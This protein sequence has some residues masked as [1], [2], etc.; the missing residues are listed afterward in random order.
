MILYFLLIFSLYFLF[1]AALLAGWNRVQKQNFQPDATNDLF[2]SVVIAVRNE[3]ENIN[4][5]LSSLQKQRFPRGQFEVLIIDDDSNDD[6]VEQIERFMKTSAHNLELLRKNNKHENVQSPKKAA[7][8]K[9]IE[10][11]K[12]DIILTTDGDTWFGPGWIENTIAPFR[13]ENVNFV[14]SPVALASGKQLFGRMQSLEFAS[15]IGTGAALIGLRYPLMCNGANL[16]FRKSAFQAVGGYE[17]NT[18][19]ASG[20]DVYLMQKIH[21]ASPDSVIFCNNSD[22]IVSTLPQKTWREFVHQRRRWASKWNR[23]L[24]RF[25]WILPVFLFVHY[26]SFLAAIVI[27]FIVPSAA[28]TLSVLLLTKI[29]LD[30]LFLKKVM[31]FS[32]LRF[33]LLTVLISELIYPFYALLIGSMVHVGGYEWKGRSFKQ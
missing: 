14:S 30:T 5:L 24:L 15:L 25:S 7:L 29:V 18:N 3:G 8:S 22:A 26:A 6:T 27:A 33:N 4:R 17:G 20:D 23:Y 2:V 12:G 10:A 31:D 32:K 28:L 9:G 19:D 21:A 13:N 1:V 16:A 11:A